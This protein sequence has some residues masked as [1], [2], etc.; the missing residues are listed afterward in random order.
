VSWLLRLPAC[1][2]VCPGS[3]GMLGGA[4]SCGILL[5]PNRCPAPLLCCCRSLDHLEVAALLD[6]VLGVP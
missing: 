5:V 3:R 4:A 2:P 1:L 6:D